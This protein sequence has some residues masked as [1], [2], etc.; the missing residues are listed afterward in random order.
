MRMDPQKVLHLT[1]IAVILRESTVECL[2]RYHRTGPISPVMKPWACAEQV[3]QTFS[4]IFAAMWFTTRS[5]CRMRRR[6]ENGEAM[7]RV[8]LSLENRHVTFS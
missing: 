7:K 5:S 3:V 1:D 6:A 4:I 8:F 2:K